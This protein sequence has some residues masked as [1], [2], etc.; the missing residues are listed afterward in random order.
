[1]SRPVVHRI[2]ASLLALAVLGFASA[3]ASHVHLSPAGDDGPRIAHHE[4]DA[5]QPTGGPAEGHTCV[6]CNSAEA[7]PALAHVALPTDSV[8]P[9]LRGIVRDVPPVA[10]VVLYRVGPERAPPT[11]A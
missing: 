10:G 1:M 5:P 7:S 2:G 4:D 11:R 8:E 3:N 6:S 9:A